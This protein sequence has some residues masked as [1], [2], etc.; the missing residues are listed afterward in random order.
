VWH[1]CFHR[2][3]LNISLFPWKCIRVLFP[4][5]TAFSAFVSYLRPQLVRTGEG[6]FASNA[7]EQA[8]IPIQQSGLWDW[9]TSDQLVRFDTARVTPLGDAGPQPDF[10]VYARNRQGDIVRFVASS[11]KV[12]RKS[13]PVFAETGGEEPVNSYDRPYM[14]ML[15]ITLTGRFCGNR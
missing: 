9:G 2:A 5:G 11:Y 1:R 12:G 7:L 10:A 15:E 8:T 14:T 13:L 6:F 4:D 3:C